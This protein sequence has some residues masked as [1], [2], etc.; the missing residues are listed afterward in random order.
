MS[1]YGLAP[2]SKLSKADAE[3]VNGFIWQYLRKITKERLAD[4]TVPIGVPVWDSFIGREKFA[5]PSESPIE[6]RLVIAMISDPILS[7]KFVQQASVGPYRI[8]IAFP[9]LKFGIECDGR[10]Y[11]STPGDLAEDAR[12]TQYLGSLG[13]TIKRFSGRQINKGIAW[14]LQEMRSIYLNLYDAGWK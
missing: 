13:W 2:E 11:H 3:K 12:R 6:Q 7:G 9:H 14:C 8:D 4:R 5:A 10:K 1:F